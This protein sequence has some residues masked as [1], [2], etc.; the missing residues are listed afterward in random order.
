MDSETLFPIKFIP[1]S[2]AR[3]IAILCS[4]LLVF[5]Y[6]AASLRFWTRTFIIRNLGSDDIFLLLSLV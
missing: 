2:G 5:S 3:E 1:T 4:V 6:I